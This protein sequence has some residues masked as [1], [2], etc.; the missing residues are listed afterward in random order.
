MNAEVQIRIASRDSVA[1]VP[2][3]ALRAESDIPV[4]ALMLGIAESELREMLSASMPESSASATGQRMQQRSTG[5]Y[6]EL[7]D[8]IEISQIQQIIAKRRNG[9][10]LTVEEQTVIDQ[11][12]ARI[13]QSGG[14]MNGGGRNVLETVSITDYQFG[15]SYWV[16]TMQ[17]GGTLPLSVQTGLTDLEYSEIVAGLDSDA[18]VLLLPSSSLF[19]QQE[20]IQNRL[21][22]MFESVT[23]FQAVGRGPGAG[24]GRGPGS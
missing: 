19:E 12:Q 10:T 1:A 17:D 4:T 14:G 6:I 23:P 2:T 20:A 5:R 18:E 16:V 3:M 15:G 11:L 22:A 7:P 21:S 9:E 24:T 8:G 13:R